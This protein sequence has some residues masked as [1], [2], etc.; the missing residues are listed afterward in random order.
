M[1]SENKKARPETEPSQAADATGDLVEH[2]HVLVQTE[3]KAEDG[4]RLDGTVGKKR[5]AGT[6]EHQPWAEVLVP[7]EQHR[8]DDLDR[9]HQDGESEPDELH[10]FSRDGGHGGGRSDGSD[11]ERSEQWSGV[12]IPPLFVTGSGA[13]PVIGVDRNLLFG[14]RP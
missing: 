6:S 5:D 1:E 11:H 14:W 10:E 3:G 13:G 2:L 7:E 9:S 4:Y 8:G 12:Q